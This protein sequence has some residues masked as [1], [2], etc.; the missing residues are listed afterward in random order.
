MKITIDELMSMSSEEQ[1]SI[2]ENTNHRNAN[3]KV[4]ETITIDLMGLSNEEI[5]ARY[6]FVPMD[7]FIEDL[8]QKL[9]SKRCNFGD[10]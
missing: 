5:I 4:S 10:V 9:L 1:D 7:D 8:K 6:N 3:E 2:F